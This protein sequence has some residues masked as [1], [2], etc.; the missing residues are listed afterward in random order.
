MPNSAHLAAAVRTKMV[1]RKRKMIDARY[2]RGEQVKEI[3]YIFPSYWE[4]WP[5]HKWELTWI[6]PIGVTNCP[7][8]P[9]FARAPVASVSSMLRLATRCNCGR[10]RRKN[11]IIEVRKSTGRIKVSFPAWANNKYQQCCRRMCLSKCKQHVSNIV[12]DS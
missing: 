4:L 5:A 11:R 9:H 1:G 8:L 6:G 10:Q 3:L 7:P 2:S 12:R